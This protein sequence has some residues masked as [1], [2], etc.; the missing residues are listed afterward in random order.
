M[1]QT[2]HVNQFAVGNQGEIVSRGYITRHVQRRE[3]LVPAQNGA[4]SPEMRR[5][6]FYVASIG[7]VTL[8]L[9]FNG[10]DSYGVTL[11]AAAPLPADLR[12]V[13]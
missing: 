10:G 13:K 12:P 5:Q 9:R 6:V 7:G 8:S 3:L 2:I 4:C 11:S 1:K